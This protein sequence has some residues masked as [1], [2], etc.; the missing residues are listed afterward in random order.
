M[1]GVWVRV[2]Y[3]PLLWHGFGDGWRTRGRWRQRVS[4]LTC[5]AKGAAEGMQVVLEVM[6]RRVM[7]SWRELKVG[8][9]GVED[10]WRGAGCG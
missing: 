4:R 8:E 7:R 1:S 2:V 10:D 6:R 9:I 3:F 5:T